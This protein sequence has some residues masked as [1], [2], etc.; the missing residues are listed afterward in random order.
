MLTEL[1]VVSSLQ[2]P[3]EENTPREQSPCEQ[4][5]PQ[6]SDI[7]RSEQ[8]RDDPHPTSLTDAFL[9]KRGGVAENS[10]TLT[11]HEIPRS[12]ITWA[13]LYMSSSLF[14]FLPILYIL[15]LK[16]RVC[17]VCAFFDKTQQ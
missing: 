7:E 5:L 17:D 12:M 4:P 13:L 14:N 16:A 3:H 11:K 1:Q 2:S 8:E 6:S 10:V 9:R 15:G